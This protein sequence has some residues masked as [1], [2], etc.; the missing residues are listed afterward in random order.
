M[1]K[2]LCA[3]M[4]ADKGRRDSGLALL[5]AFDAIDLISIHD[6]SAV[7]AAVMKVGRVQAIADRVNVELG[8]VLP[9]AGDCQQMSAR[10]HLVSV[11]KVFEFPKAFTTKKPISQTSPP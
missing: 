8:R 10:E 2:A 5:E 4:H 1:I 3:V 6:A 9:A 11:R 7:D